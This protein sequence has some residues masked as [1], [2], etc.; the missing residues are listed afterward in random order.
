M[1]RK[2]K[3]VDGNNN[4][5]NLEIKV[6]NDKLSISGEMGGS[7]GQIVDSIK[8]LGE[9][10]TKLIEIWNKYHLNDMNAG[11]IKQTQV[12]DKWK[13]EG[14]KYDYYKAKQL[15]SSIKPDGTVMNALEYQAYV[16]GLKKII[17]ETKEFSEHMAKVM[18]DLNLIKETQ[19]WIKVDKMVIE[20]AKDALT[21]ADF[22]RCTNVKNPEYM[23]FDSTYQIKRMV[24]LINKRLHEQLKEMS[25]R[26]DEYA[27]QSLLYDEHPETGHAYQYG[28]GWIKNPLPEEIEDELDDL[29]D[30]IEIEEEGTPVA[31]EDTELFEDFSDPDA[32]HALAIL[33]ELNKEDVDDIDETNNCYGECNYE[34]QGTNYFC[35]N[36]EEMLQAVEDYMDDSLWAFTPS[37]LGGYGAL[38][39]LDSSAVDLILKP[40]Q[41]QCEGGNEAIKELVD[42]DE[43]KYEMAVDAVDADGFAHFL[44]G[45]DGIGMECH[46]F[47]ETYYA[48][49]RD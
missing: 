2:I 28:T 15:L 3:F 25:I 37:F 9:A 11:T 16:E 41:E 24:D 17:N 47:V 48:C 43:N 4:R 31:L 45:Y 20:A 1:E 32:A 49:R 33:L 46:D 40:I 44:N 22:K 38:R 8:P 19:R 27:L 6:D 26:H 23:F 7:C 12:I 35:G 5:I 34:V 36:K 10:Q 39:K 14:N 13:D 42:W 18:S 29:L 30:E 21:R